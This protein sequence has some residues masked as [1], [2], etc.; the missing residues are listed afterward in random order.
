MEASYSEQAALP[1]ESSRGFTMYPESPDYCSALSPCVST[2]AVG[3][4]GGTLHCLALFFQEGG[5]FPLDMSFFY[6]T[7]LHNF[8]L[9][10]HVSVAL[11]LVAEELTNQGI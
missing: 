1:V 9:S 7:H 6:S 10:P 3:K 5:F 4:P 2:A 11:S 8:C